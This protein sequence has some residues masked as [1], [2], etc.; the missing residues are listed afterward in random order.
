MVKNNNENRETIADAK[1]WLQTTF[2]GRIPMLEPALPQRAVVSEAVPL[3]VPVSRMVTR[4]GRYADISAGYSRIA[5]AV[6]ASIIPEERFDAIITALEQEEL[7]DAAADVL[8]KE[9]DEL[10]PAA[11][12]QS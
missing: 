5:L 10:A 6:V 2:G 3:Q 7:D 8:F 9:S 4:S 1:D 12:P 11:A